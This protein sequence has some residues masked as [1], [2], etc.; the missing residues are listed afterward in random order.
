MRI[1]TVDLDEVHV[2]HCRFEPGWRWSTTFGPMM[3]TPSCPIRHL[4]Y[5]IS[6]SLRV[7]MDDGQAMDLGPGIRVRDPARPRQV[8]ASATSRG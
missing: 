8:G 1:E 2:G 3:G 5:T 6:G 4:G 7:V